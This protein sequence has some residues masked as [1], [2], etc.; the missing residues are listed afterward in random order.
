MSAD[1]AD[2]VESAPEDEPQ[3]PALPGV[4]ESQSLFAFLSTP[5]VWAL[6]LLM[7]VGVGAS[8]MVMG[9]VGNMVVALLPAST[10]SAWLLSAAMTKPVVS[11]IALQI[12]ANQVKLLA[13]ANTVSRLLG[14]LLSDAL[15][16]SPINSQRSFPT[17]SRIT[18]LLGAV[19]LSSGAYAWAAFGLR[20]T[21]GLP[22]F[23]LSVGVGYGL[24]FTLVPAITV[25]SF[26]NRHFGR[27]WGMLSYCCALGSLTY[28]LLYALV[29]DAVASKHDEHRGGKGALCTAGPECFRASFIV[30]LVGMGLAGVA[31][32]PVWKRWRHHL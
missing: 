16:P 15:A 6:G 23:S 9:S 28:S 29:S 4:P 14:G 25:A 24:V 26:G 12:R 27:N 7:V 22:L 10:P 2:N 17:V 1:N 21:D 18:L 32:V 8:E 30:A 3:A 31:L 19:L 20:T 5:S 11:P 13:A